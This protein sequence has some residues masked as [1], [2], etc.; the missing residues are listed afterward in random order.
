MILKSDKVSF[1]KLLRVAVVLKHSIEWHLAFL[2]TS[3]ILQLSYD[4]CVLD[5]KATIHE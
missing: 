5:S 3:N 4:V 2:T 1:S